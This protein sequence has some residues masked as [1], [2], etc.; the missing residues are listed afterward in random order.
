M[1][2][3]SRYWFRAGYFDDIPQRGAIRVQHGQL[4]IAVFRTVNDDVF[5][6][7]DKCPHKGGPLSAGIVHNNCV[8]CP[9]HNWDISLETGEALGADDG[10]TSKF[11]VKL[12]D[13]VV[14]LCIEEPV[15]LT[16]L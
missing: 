12:D 15:H 7:E 11:K 9:L 3:H 5:A 4:R 2:A 13:G 10:R 6:L 14:M 16:T 8:T 1:N